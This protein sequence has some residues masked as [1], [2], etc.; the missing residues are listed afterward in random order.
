M[1]KPLAEEI[2][3]GWK[4]MT[5]SLVYENPWIQLFHEEV[6]TPG[7]TDGIYGRVH[8]RGVAVGVVPIDAEGNTWLVRQSRYTLGHYTW[9][10][11]EGGA[12]EGE[13]T[14]ACAKRELEEEVGLTAETWRKII[15]LHTSN[16]VTDERG[17]V[18]VAEGLSAGSQNLESTED[19]EV[20]KLPLK[21]A[22]EMVLN[23]EITDAMS[24][25]ALLWVAREYGC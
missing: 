20:L 23:G 3:G 15:D 16:S 7:N 10:I 19:I 22:V 25:S 14:L 6:K 4:R 13:E 5:S 12:G 1:S 2:V 11:P 9:E 17:E 18:F 8:F 21:N 24:I